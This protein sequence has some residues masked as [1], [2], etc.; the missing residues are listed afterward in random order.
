MLLWWLFVFLS[1]V[2]R[3]FCVICCM[4]SG[5]MNGF[6]S[7]RFLGIDLFVSSNESWKFQFIGHLPLFQNLFFPPLCSGDEHQSLILTLV[8]NLMEESHSLIELQQLFVVDEIH[9]LRGASHEFRS[10]YN[11]TLKH[12]DM[13][14][15]KDG[16]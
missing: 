14:D 13:W 4:W 3:C 1:K 6:V 5:Y 7:C 11:K 2:I 16:D 8:R 12:W 15:Y 10:P 9:F